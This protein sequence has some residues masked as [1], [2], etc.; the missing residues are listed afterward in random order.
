MPTN[1]S[2]HTGKGEKEK[3]VTTKSDHEDMMQTYVSHFR[4]RFLSGTFRHAGSLIFWL[5][6]ENSKKRQVQPP[7]SF[8]DPLEESLL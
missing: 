5:A 2:N 8:S 6:A 4:G 1:M 3:I 7:T